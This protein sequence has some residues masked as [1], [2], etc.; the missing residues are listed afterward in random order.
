MPRKKFHIRNYLNLYLAALSGILLGLS[1]S[2]LGLEYFIWFALVPLLIGLRRTQGIKDALKTGFISGLFYFGITLYWVYFTTVL[3]LV[4]LV[5]YCAG[6][7]AL[8]GAVYKYLELK[9]KPPLTC[10]LLLIS[11]AWVLVEY[12]RANLFS[13]F[14]WALL[15]YAQ[16]ENI[17]VIQMADITGLWGVS[18]LIA[19]INVSCYEVLSLFTKKSSLAVRPKLKKSFFVVLTALVLYA[20]FYAYGDVRLH[21]KPAVQKTIKVSLV[22]G[23]IAQHE[24]WKRSLREH[25]LRVYEHYTRM[26]SFDEPDIIIWPETS[27][28]GYL[29][30]KSLYDKIAKLASTLKMPVLIGAPR[31]TGGSGEDRVYNSAAFFSGEGK[32]LDVYDKLWP[33]PFA[34][35]IPL[36]GIFGF[37][38]N[39]TETADFS[40]GQIMT[41]FRVKGINFGVLICYEGINSSLVRDFVNSGAEFMVNITNEAWFLRSTEPYQHLS[42][43][44]FRAAEHKVNVVRAAN[45]GISCVIDPYGRVVKKVSKAGHELFVDGFLSAELTIIK[46]NTFYSRFGNVFIVLIGFTSVILLILLARRK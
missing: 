6:Y 35:Y 26:A 42:A 8:F 7:I 4:L 29:N 46:E 27:L 10:R 2:N 24:K 11:F 38:R 34:E 20:G 9:I 28:P 16:Y 33:V 31:E 12:L 17:A 14:G 36:P 43:S 13:G 1:F 30:E 22:Q 5:L 32:L 41:I 40:K 25:I 15:A 3:G 19:F 21:Q 44:V 18:W 39:T 45:T 37:L 23:N